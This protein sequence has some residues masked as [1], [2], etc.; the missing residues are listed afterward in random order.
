M[1]DISTLIGGFDP[2]T[3]E[4][5]PEFDNSPLPSGDYYA[6]IKKAEV[7][8]TKKGDG[9]LCEIEFDILG[10]VVDKSCKGRKLWSR[11]NLQNPSAKCQQIGQAQFHGLRIAVGKPACQDTDELIGSNLVVT[12]GIEN[13]T[14][15]K[16]EIKKYVALEGYDASAAEAPKAAA[17]APAAAAPAA[18]KA[19][20]W[21]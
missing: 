12:V 14:L 7:K 1:S 20:P 6:E 17:P 21:D 19:Q 5:Q 18:K 9:Q 4:E 16:N 3:Y 8:P 11:F 15:D 13:G 2:E 10:Q